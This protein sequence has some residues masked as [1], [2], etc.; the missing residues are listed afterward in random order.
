MEQRGDSMTVRVP[1]NC[2][3][4]QINVQSIKEMQCQILQMMIVILT[5][6]CLTVSNNI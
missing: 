6:N 5:V 3:H 1:S 2:F 4:K